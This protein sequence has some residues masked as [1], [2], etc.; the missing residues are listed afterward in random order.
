MIVF[1]LMGLAGILNNILSTYLKI[2]KK[3]NNIYNF[4][5]EWI[6]ER[7]Y[8]FYDGLCLLL[9]TFFVLFMSLIYLKV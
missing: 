3:Y 4:F 1:F 7:R 6:M 2:M 9:Y 5:S 8:N